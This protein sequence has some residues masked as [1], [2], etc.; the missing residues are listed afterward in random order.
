MHQNNSLLRY[1]PFAHE[2]LIREFLDS[3]NKIGLEELINEKTK[4]LAKLVESFRIAI[5]EKQTNLYD[6]KLAVD[7]TQVIQKISLAL[8]SKF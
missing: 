2:N 5:L 8:D 4:P 6:L 1:Q 7:V 3:K